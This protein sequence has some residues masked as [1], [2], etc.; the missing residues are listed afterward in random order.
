MFGRPLQEIFD[1]IPTLESAQPPSIATAEDELTCLLPTKAILPPPP[2]MPRVSVAPYHSPTSFEAALGARA[3]RSSDVDLTR[4]DHRLPVA[5][6]GSSPP[7]AVVIGLRQSAFA[8]PS[9]ATIAPALVSAPLAAPPAKANVTTKPPRS[10]A[11]G[12]LKLVA[13]AAMGALAGW[14]LVATEYGQLRWNDVQDA[15]ASVAFEARSATVETEIDLGIVPPPP[16]APMRV[17][18]VGPGSGAKW[19]TVPQGPLVS[20]TRSTPPPLELRRGE[21]RPAS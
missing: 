7:P 12:V 13:V 20:A 17:R 19:T 15:A 11:G 16:P 10:A 9:A 8:A 18:A 6:L 21:P 3:S 5:R 14:A 4:Y 2:A 1:D